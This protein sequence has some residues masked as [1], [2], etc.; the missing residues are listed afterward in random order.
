MLLNYYDSLRVK[1]NEEI[2]KTKKIKKDNFFKQHLTL[3]SA[4][5]LGGDHIFVI[6]S[7]KAFKCLN[8]QMFKR[9]KY[10]SKYLKK[11][12]KQK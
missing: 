2:F 10:Q 1:K 3:F 7:L 11:I 12:K 5:L 4:E 8:V 9:I 6:F